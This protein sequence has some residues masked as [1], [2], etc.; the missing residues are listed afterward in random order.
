MI[1]KY[2]KIFN[3]ACI[4]HEHLDSSL[5]TIVGKYAQIYIAQFMR[6]AYCYQQNQPFYCHAVY[7]EEAVQRLQVRA[8]PIKTHLCLTKIL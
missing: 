1:K 6:G 7:Q 2:L 5:Q 3:F 4:V 8:R